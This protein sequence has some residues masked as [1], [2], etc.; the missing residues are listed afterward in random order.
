RTN[1]TETEVEGGGEA[2]GDTKA[3]AAAVHMNG[4]EHG[5]RAGTGDPGGQGAIPTDPLLLLAP[6]GPEEGA[7]SP[8]SPIDSQPLAVERQQHVD[9]SSS[10]PIP[11][12]I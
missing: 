7:Q 8:R 10:R 6:Q 9:P 12:R 3:S 4:E 1:R 11:S 2:A 5:A